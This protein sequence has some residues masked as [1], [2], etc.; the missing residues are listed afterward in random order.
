MYDLMFY[1]FPFFDKFRIPSMIL[2]LVMVTLPVLAAFGIK[3]IVDLV[4][5]NDTHLAKVVQYSAFV[6]TGL[7]FVSLLFGSG[8]G[9]WFTGRV[10][11]HA[12]SNQRTAQM[13]RA[14]SGYMSDMFVGDVRFAFGISAVVFWVAFAL[15]KRKVSVSIFLITVVVL[16]FADL[17][18]V[19]KRAEEYE[20]AQNAE[21]LFTK[22]DYVK[23]IENQKDEE[24]FRM[25]NL[26][27]DG[28]VGSFRNNSNFNS[29]FL[30]QDL[31]GYS[32]IKPRSIQDYMDVVG[33]FNETLWRMLNVKYLVFDKAN[34]MPSLK[35]ISNSESSFVYEFKDVLPRAYFVDSVAT[36]ASLEMLNKVKANAFDPGS[37]SYTTDISLEIDKPD[38]NAYVNITNYMDEKIELDVKA[39]GNNLMFLGDT[40]FPNGWTAYIDEEETPIYK[41]NHGFRGIIVPEGEHKVKFIYLPTSFVISK[42]LALSLSSFVIIG[43]CFGLYFERK[44]KNIV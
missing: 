27:Q 30:L 29:Y 4:K 39:T 24:P 33:P 28:S 21:E 14:L 12:A 41:L 23:T 43:L 26:K 35:L 32:A 5:E 42:Y 9:E 7:F 37:I 2:L 11:E 13:F 38:T 20:H 16:S 34:P 31:Y 15:I 6:L 19:N 25:L 22:P 8:L 1:Y 44:Q 36:L 3:G 17:Y 10:N 18:R 40:Y